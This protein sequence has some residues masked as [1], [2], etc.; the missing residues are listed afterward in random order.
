MDSEYPE[1]VV[2]A[3]IINSERKLL[4]ITSDKWKGLLTVPGGHVEVGETMKEALKR[5][6]REEVG[7]E[8]EEIY[9]PPDVQDAI[10][11][12]EFWK[13]KHFIFIDFMCKCKEGNV[14]ADGVEVK[15]YLWA[16]PRE[17]LNMNLG[18]FTRV[19]LERY[20]KAGAFAKLSQR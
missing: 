3:F 18:T 13:K 1:A 20:L 12:P 4:L 16:D 17:A 8:I 7:L 19:S 15:D 10:F 9:D 5:E 6:I 14:K 2:G 11:P